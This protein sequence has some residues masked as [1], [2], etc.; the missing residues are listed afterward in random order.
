MSS[1]SVEVTSFPNLGFKKPSISSLE[2]FK[3]PS[4]LPASRGLL[5]KQQ[6]ILNE[7]ARSIQ[8]DG[9]KVNS[10]GEGTACMCYTNIV[11]CA[12]IYC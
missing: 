7:L 3:S 12:Y 6:T 5:S 2:K 11:I 8:T 9:T 4:P 1:K 10:V